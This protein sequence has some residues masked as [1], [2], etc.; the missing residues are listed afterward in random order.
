MGG[1]AKK[2]NLNF[3][4]DNQRISRIRL[5]YEEPFH[6]N[7]TIIMHVSGCTD[8][9]CLF[10][11]CVGMKRIIEHTKTC[12]WRS[13][14]THMQNCKDPKCRVLGCSNIK[15]IINHKTSTPTCPTCTGLLNLCVY[16]AS[17][18]RNATCIMHD[19]HMIKEKI[20]VANKTAAQ[21]R[22]HLSLKAVHQ[23]P[24]PSVQKLYLLKK[25]DTF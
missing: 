16:H 13:I 14:A 11:G 5:P 4:G 24:I 22:S 21:K 2:R 15:L 20:R 10:L 8:A 3:V 25:R 7:A 12:N 19:C 18:C 6:Q 17:V 1:C 23:F 9:T